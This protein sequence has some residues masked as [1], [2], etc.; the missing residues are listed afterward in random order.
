MFFYIDCSS[1]LRALV[2]HIFS[3]EPGERSLAGRHD[4]EELV[5]H[6]GSGQASDVTGQH[7]CGDRAHF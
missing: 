3:R 6:R 7:R 2:T 4:P 5:L 1:P